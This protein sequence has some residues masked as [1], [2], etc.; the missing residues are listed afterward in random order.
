MLFASAVEDSMDCNEKVTNRIC[1]PVAAKLQ[2]EI[3]KRYL[4]PLLDEMD[5]DDGIYKNII[6]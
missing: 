3:V 2:D 4:K 1:G 5:C 6:I